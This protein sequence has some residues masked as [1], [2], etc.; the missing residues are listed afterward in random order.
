MDEQRLGQA[1]LKFER[2]QAA[3]GRRGPLPCDRK[4]NG[5]EERGID[6]SKQLLFLIEENPEI[7]TG[8]LYDKVSFGHGDFTASLRDL[9]E[10]GKVLTG[11]KGRAKTYF[12]RKKI[13]VV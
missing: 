12:S 9:L 8:D 11:Y 5:R 10:S 2:E 4:P 3:M 1:M 13:R 6:R 7:T